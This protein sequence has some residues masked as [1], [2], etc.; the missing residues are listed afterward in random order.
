MPANFRVRLAPD[1]QCGADCGAEKVYTHYRYDKTPSKSMKLAHYVSI[2]GCIVLS[3]FSVLETLKVIQ[4]N[5][6]LKPHAH[7]ANCG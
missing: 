3:Y 2:D 5:F 7:Q 6:L 4:I 1:S